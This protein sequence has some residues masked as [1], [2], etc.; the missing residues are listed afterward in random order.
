MRNKKEYC[1]YRYTLVS[2]GEVIYIGKTDASLKARIDAHEREPKFAPYMGL[3]KI[4][5]IRLANRVETDV[6]ERF[7]INKLK[8]AINEKDLEEGLS[9]SFDI[10]LPE[11]IPYE[12]YVAP[13]KQTAVD[14][15]G[16]EVDLALYSAALDAVV[17]HDNVIRTEFLHP[18]GRLPFNGSYLQVT[19]PDVSMEIG[20]QTCYVQSISPY[21]LYE[22]MKSPLRVEAS[23]YAAHME[24]VELPGD[25][26]LARQ[27]AD[28]LILFAKDG[29]YSEDIGERNIMDIEGFE[30]AIGY[31]SGVLHRIGDTHY[32]E[33]DS[34]MECEFG[35]IM[36]NIA[37]KELLC[38]RKALYQGEIELER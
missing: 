15:K 20:P 27:L 36:E 22:I 32:A 21:A 6:V 33:V 23:I 12:E 24:W 2:S 10:S 25:I 11:W 31:F 37:K 28:N 18:T 19:E 16:L 38:Y 34:D 29:Y 4:D 7:L 1:V 14:K 35:V 8:P 9:G 30:S 5:F 26:V 17:N 3:W 13:K